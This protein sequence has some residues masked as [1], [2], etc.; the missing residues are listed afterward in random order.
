MTTSITNSTRQ[1]SVRSTEAHKTK[2]V[3]GSTSKLLPARNRVG[4]APERRP[5]WTKRPVPS[6]RVAPTQVD[7]DLQSPTPATASTDVKSGWK[8]IHR[9]PSK[10]QTS[11]VVQLESSPSQQTNLLSCSAPVPEIQAR[12]AELTRS[13]CFDV[14][15]K[16]N[17]CKKN[18]QT[19]E[20][21]WYSKDNVVLFKECLVDPVM[22]ALQNRYVQQRLATNLFVGSKTSVVKAAIKEHKQTIKEMVKRLEPKA[23]AQTEYDLAYRIPNGVACN[24]SKALN[25]QIASLKTEL[26]RLARCGEIVDDLRTN[27]RI[28]SEEFSLGDLVALAGM[29]EDQINPWLTAGFKA[30]EAVYAHRAGLSLDDFVGILRSDERDS[31]CKGSQDL[32]QGDLDNIRYLLQAK[33]RLPSMSG[34]DFKLSARLL[35]EKRPSLDTLAVMGSR[36]IPVNEHT[37][38]Q[39]ELQVDRN[40][41][42][43]K[44]LAEGHMGKAYKIPMPGGSFMVFKEE[45]DDVADQAVNAGVPAVGQGPNLTGRTLASAAVAK[46]LGIASAPTST[47]VILKFEGDPVPRYGE[48]STFVQ[49]QTVGSSLGANAKIPLSLQDYQYLDQRPKTELHAV[50][51]RYGFQ[52]A[53]LCIS[54]QGEHF[55][56]LSSGSGGDFVTPLDLKSPYIRERLSELGFWAATSAQVDLNPTNIMINPRRGNTFDLVSID[57]NMSGG[58]LH[59]HPACQMATP[60][61]EYPAWQKAVEQTVLQAKSGD[62]G[63]VIPLP[64]KIGPVQRAGIL[65][66]TEEQFAARWNLKPDNLKAPWA[67]MQG[68]QRR[69]LEKNPDGTLKIPVTEA[70]WKATDTGNVHASG[71]PRV[72]SKQ[73]RN[74]YLSLTEH[75]VKQ[76]M[77][78]AVGKEE[79]DAAWQRVM[80]I[81]DELLIP[82]HIRVVNS[83][84]EW[85]DPEVTRA[86]GLEP[87]VLRKAANDAAGMDVHTAKGQ[88]YQRALDHGVSATI[89]FAQT[90]SRMHATGKLDMPQENGTIRSAWTRGSGA[91]AY[92]DEKAILERALAKPR[93]RTKL[94]PEVRKAPAQP[95]KVVKV[96]KPRVSKRSTVVPR[97]PQTRAIRRPNPLPQEKA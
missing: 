9:P 38:P 61:G 43:F 89:A 10:G 6:A 3:L 46:R 20:I 85:N 29:H 75:T 39:K 55:L 56:E 44:L 4:A 21:K 91:S 84:N 79:Q 78:G 59:Y 2:F 88:R 77:Y 58:K 90:N 13:Q 36:Q 15:I 16:H 69:L 31:S 30:E 11:L 12:V 48:L 37:L 80:A 33:N 62:S 8:S 72:I 54:E 19:G 71:V 22:V 87:D 1:Q 41:E 65:A 47:P 94:K 97:Q 60:L 45:G 49:G 25:D 68:F 76:E 93:N 24:E 95:G 23:A 7:A 66:M 81:Q 53:A 32:N 70:D 17:Y 74:R 82:D 40:A 50:A 83:H 64:D 5:A 18:Q 51:H 67:A 35:L 26:R 28:L 96:T 14:A 27:D 92:F 57:N 63:P 73:L 42:G 52:G 34:E 86:M